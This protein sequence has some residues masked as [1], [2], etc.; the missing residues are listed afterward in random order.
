LALEFVIH[1]AWTIY[2]LLASIEAEL[3][4]L[5]SLFLNGAGFL[6]T[7]VELDLILVASNQSSSLRSDDARFAH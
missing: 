4:M 1:Q 7:R 2:W 5:G 3:K 6:F